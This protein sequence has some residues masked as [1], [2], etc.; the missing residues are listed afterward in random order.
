MVR[1]ITKGLAA[2]LTF[3]LAGSATADPRPISWETLRGGRPAECATFLENFFAEPDCAKQSLMLG[4]LSKKFVQCSPGVAALDGLSVTIA[5]Y[6]HPLELEFFGVRE[7]LLI[8][9]LRGDCRHPPPPLPDQIVSVEFP[10]GLDINA[11]PVWVTGVLRVIE[12]ETHLA[13]M[14]YS[15]EAISVAPAFHPDVPAGR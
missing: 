7:F 9:S 4:L 2:C 10:F 11:D 12:G 13:K 15:I 6:A 5:G 3:A 1:A 8:P 14:S